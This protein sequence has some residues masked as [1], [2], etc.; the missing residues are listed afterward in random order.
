MQLPGLCL[1]F[2]VQFPRGLQHRRFRV[3]ADDAAD[4]RRKAECEE[5][6]SRAEINRACCF[7]NPSFCATVRKYRADTRST[8]RAASTVTH[9]GICPVERYSFTLDG[10]DGF[11]R[12]RRSATDLSS[13]PWSTLPA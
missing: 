8:R 1:L 5:P 11:S 9:A 6:W 7:D 4:I 12:L 10:G 3:D 2:G 13:K